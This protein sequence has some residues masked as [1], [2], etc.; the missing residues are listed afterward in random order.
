M[1]AKKN[2]D[3]YY[4]TGKIDI[5]YMNELGADSVEQMLRLIDDPKFGEDTETVYKAKY[6]RECLK[7]IYAESVKDEQSMF[8]FNI[9]RNEA[10]RQLF[11]KQLVPIEY[12][13]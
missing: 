12:I 6:V 4:S 9:S 8:S 11:L 10:K 3:R 1:I 13:K 5:Y 2:I 7:D